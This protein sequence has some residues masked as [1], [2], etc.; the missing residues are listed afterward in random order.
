MYICYTLLKFAYLFKKIYFFERVSERE[1]AQ[2]GRGAEK[3][4]KHTPL[5]SREPNLHRAD[6]QNEE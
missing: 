3:R 4:K 2:T 1:Q 5:L 6:L